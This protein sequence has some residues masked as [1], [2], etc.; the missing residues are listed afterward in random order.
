[1]QIATAL[2][3]PVDIRARLDAAVV[4]GREDAAGWARIHP[5]GSTDRFHGDAVGWLGAPPTGDAATADLNEV[6]SASRM[7][8]A[9]GNARA[10]ELAARAGWETW[11]AA[12]D[13]IGRTQGVE[14]GRRAAQLVALAAERTDEISDDAKLKH[15][16]RRPFELDPSIN[17]I[18]ARPG[19]NPSFPSG[20]SSGAYAAGLMLAALV[21]QRATEFVDLAT[22]VA[23]SRVYGGVH[24]PTDVIAGARLAAAVV[25]DVLR[26]DAAGLP[27]R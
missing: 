16:R 15:G 24:F 6:R 2:A 26:R 11:Q 19:G 22:E 5:T 18:V 20:H 3:V 17:P 25:N 4:A 8:S 13:D 21:P 14:Q 1:M 9:A 12:I 27:P 10:I 7:R 23:W